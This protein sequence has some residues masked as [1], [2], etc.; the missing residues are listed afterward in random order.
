MEE[1]KW[2]HESERIAEEESKWN[3]GDENNDQY[4]PVIITYLKSP[5]NSLGKDPP[6]TVVREDVGYLLN[7]RSCENYLQITYPYKKFTSQ[8]IQRCYDIFLLALQKTTHVE[9]MTENR[10]DICYNKYYINSGTFRE[11]RKS[12]LK[13]MFRS[14]LLLFCCYDVDDDVDDDD[15]CIDKTW[16]H[17]RGSTITEFP[18]FTLKEL[19][20]ND[21]KYKIFRQ[22]WNG[23]PDFVSSY[24]IFRNYFH[25]PHDVINLIMKFLQPKS[26]FEIKNFDKI[27]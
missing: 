5:F 24:K 17:S 27:F 23:L 26:Y 11:S 15:D 10:T 21:E 3:D 2:E 8:D 25:L 16:P 20:E 14:S 13:V 7:L 18:S 4:E 6:V 19:L 22:F 12:V 1:F 9:R